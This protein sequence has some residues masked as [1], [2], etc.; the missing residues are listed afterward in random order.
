MVLEVLGDV[1]LR[2]KVKGRV[3]AATYCMIPLIHAGPTN[4][5][6]SPRNL[7]RAA[8]ARTGQKARK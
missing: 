6:R 7:K 3:W 1:W 2:F 8:R 5:S 4:A